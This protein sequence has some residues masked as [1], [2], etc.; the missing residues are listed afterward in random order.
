MKGKEGIV[1]SSNDKGGLWDRLHKGVSIRS[2]TL[3][4]INCMANAIC[5]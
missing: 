2:G 1:I 5:T 3:D 4:F